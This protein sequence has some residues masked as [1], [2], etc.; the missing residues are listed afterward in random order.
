LPFG[1]RTGVAVAR[2]QF[3]PKIS[4]AVDIKETP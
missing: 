4:V 2:R 3:L 1:V